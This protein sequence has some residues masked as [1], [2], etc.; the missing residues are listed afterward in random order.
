[1]RMRN[2]IAALLLAPAA[3]FAGGYAI[4]NGNARDLALSQATVAAGNGPETAHQN[5][6]ALAGQEGL[7]ISASVEM[8]YNRTDWSD[9]LLGAASLREKANWPPEVAASY[10]NKLPNGMPYGVGLVYLV[11]GGGSLFWPNPWPGSARIVTVEQRAHLTELS[12]AIQPKGD[13]W[14]VTVVNHTDQKLVNVQIVIEDR[15]FSLGEL[16]PGETKA[17]T[18]AKGQGTLLREFVGRYNQAFQEAAQSRQ[19]AF[20]AS[21]SGHI[22]DLPN[23]TVAASF[24]SQMRRLD[25]Y[26]FS[27]VAPPGLDL[28]SVV[29]HGN[30]VLF[31]WAGDFS[32]V[33]QMNQF[34][35][36][37][38]HRDTLWRVAVPMP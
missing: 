13:G 22:S 24:L 15:I 38:T 20:G 3:A 10:G 34:S 4:P 35:P 7:G 9:Q 11:P 18:I 32:P 37:R 27:Y 36:R 30:A 14:Q 33:K 2:T 1:M 23:S 25:N 28:S 16:L 21:E 19:R 26:M 17:S 29:E 6:S 5:P 8:I 12:V 31:A